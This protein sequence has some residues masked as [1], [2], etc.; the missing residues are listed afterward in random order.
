MPGTG[1]RPVLLGRPRLDPRRP[2]AGR[3]TSS[4]GFCPPLLGPPARPHPREPS[5][6]PASGVRAGPGTMSWL[7]PPGLGPLPH[8]TRRAHPP[9]A[10]EADSCG[11]WED[12]L[13]TELQGVDDNSGLPLAVLPPSLCPPRGC[14]HSCLLSSGAAPSP[15]GSLPLTLGGLSRPDPRGWPAGLWATETAVSA[16]APA[17]RTPACPTCHRSHHC[18]PG[19]STTGTRPGR[20]RGPSA[21]RRFPGLGL[22][23]SSGQGRPIPSQT[24]PK[25]ASA[26]WLGFVTRVGGTGAWSPNRLDEDVSDLTPLTGQWTAPGRPAPV[27][28]LARH[29]GYVHS[30]DSGLS[31]LGI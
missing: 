18:S 14:S 1:T 10:S 23:T 28:R 20:A 26:P 30:K 16:P 5:P 7:L 25:R 2:G 31:E 24:E 12:V 27:L 4:V 22:P 8:Q 17:P 21:D 15:Q 3:G 13:G 29:R 11:F 19:L 9:C 6:S